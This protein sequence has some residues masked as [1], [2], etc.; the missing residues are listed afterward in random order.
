VK[1]L[2]G[3]PKEIEGYEPIAIIERV[4]DDFI[5]RRPQE[6]SRVIRK[7]Y[8]LCLTKSHKQCYKI[9]NGDLVKF[10]RS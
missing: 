5:V 2:D 6:T 10:G 9:T 4:D 8:W 3:E 7:N 1:I